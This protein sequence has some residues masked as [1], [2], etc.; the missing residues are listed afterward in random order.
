[1]QHQ[2]QV[3]YAAASLSARRAIA[4][5]LLPQLRQ[6][7]SSRT[8]LQIVRAGEKKKLK[9]HLEALAEV[10]SQHALAAL[11]RHRVSSSSAH[12]YCALLKA[13]S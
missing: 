12:M 5:N 8:G 9:Q 2:L 7:C 11:A 1:M 10:H 6:R 4:P 3:C 13:W